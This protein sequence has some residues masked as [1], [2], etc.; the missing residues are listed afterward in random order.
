[1]VTFTPTMLG[2][3]KETF[4]VKDNLASHSIPLAGRGVPGALTI[5]PTAVSFGRQPVGDQAA[6]L[7]SVSLG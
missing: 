2:V 1:M 6:S 3:R 7:G 4:T 5:T